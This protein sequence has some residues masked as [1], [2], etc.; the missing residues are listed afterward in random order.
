M[1]AFGHNVSRAM[2]PSRYSIS[3]VDPRAHLFQVRCTVDDPD[4]SG[5]VFMLPTWAPGSYLIREFA[6]HF[7]S[8]RAECEGE[9][10]PVIKL[11][12]NRWQ[13]PAVTGTVSFEADVYA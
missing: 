5:Q 11:D 6:R 9:P 12:K 2:T 13:L 7:V 8:V 10:L 1:Q 4:P 3:I